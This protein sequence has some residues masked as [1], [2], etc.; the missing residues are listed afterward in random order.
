MRLEAA[1]PLNTTEPP[2]PLSVIVP[3]NVV[4]PTWFTV[5]CAEPKRICEPATPLR[6]PG[7]IVETVIGGKRSWVLM[8]WSKPLRSKILVD[9][10][11]SSAQLVLMIFVSPACRVMKVPICVFPRK[12]LPGFVKIW[13]ACVGPA[14]S[15]M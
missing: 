2:A 14:K 15:P 3:R 1:L 7:R 8:D 9:V 12:E 10:V 11:R 6:V 5:N 4:V 13:T